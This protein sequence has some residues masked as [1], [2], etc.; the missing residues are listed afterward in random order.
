VYQYKPPPISTAKITP[1]MIFFRFVAVSQFILI[2]LSLGA[3]LLNDTN[4]ALEVSV[5]AK[6]KRRGFRRFPENGLISPI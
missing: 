5:S 6:K 4:Q 2:H 1:A 3:I